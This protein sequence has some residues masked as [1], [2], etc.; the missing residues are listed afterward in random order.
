LIL[1]ADT[2]HV[3]KD[4]AARD[5]SLNAINAKTAAKRDKEVQLC[6]PSLHP[7]LSLALL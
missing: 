5:A 7:N 3:E 2:F 4:A 1:Q 6:G